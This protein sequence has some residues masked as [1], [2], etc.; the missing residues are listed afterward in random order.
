[1]KREEY[2]KKIED[3]GIYQL[4]YGETIS[5]AMDYINGD[6]LERKGYDIKADDGRDLTKNEIIGRSNKE[7]FAKMV[8]YPEKK[9]ISYDDDYEV[10]EGNDERE[11]L[12]KKGV[13]EECQYCGEPIRIDE[14]SDYTILNCDD[15][16]N[17]A[18]WD[19]CM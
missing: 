5:D 9:L 17:V 12:S 14:D 18:I 1:M 4:R 15:C 16:M 19:N 7:A 3:N 13:V 2:V 6:R 11:D 8:T 10:I